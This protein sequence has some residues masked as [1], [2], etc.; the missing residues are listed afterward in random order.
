VLLAAVMLFSC[1]SRA[2]EPPIEAVMLPGDDGGAPAPGADGTTA[3]H[4]APDAVS[5]AVTSPDASGAPDAP[6]D[7]DAPEDQDV[8]GADPFAAAVAIDLHADVVFQVAERDRD[9]FRDDGQWTIDRARRGGLDAQFFPLWI[10]PRQG[11]QQAALQRAV[12]AFR[13][14]IDGSAGVLAVVRTASEIRERSRA[15]LLS[16]LLGIEGALPLG[17]DPANVD[18]LIELGLRYLGLTWNKSNAFAEAAADPRRPHG[19]TAAGRRLVARANDAGVLLDLA[20]ASAQTF[21]DTHRLSRSP[22]LVSH[23]GLR[24][25][26]DI[27][28]NIDDLQ[29]L[30]LA[31]S[32]GVLGIVWHSGFLADL[33]AGQTVAPL[34]ALL[35]AYDHARALGALPALALGSD[36]DGGIRPPQELAAI[37]LLPALPLALRDRGWSDDEIIA[38][39][40]ENFLRLLDAAASTVADTASPSPEDAPAAFA[41]DANTAAADLSPASTSPA[42][43]AAPR[44]WP[45][46]V[47]ST[48]PLSRDAARL[49]DRLLLP[50]PMVDP[51]TAIELEWSGDDAATAAVL[52]IWGQPDAPLVVFGGLSATARDRDAGT[53]A[54]LRLDHR[55]NGRL[56][57]DAAAL[58]ERR[59]TIV[60]AA[61][62]SE[63]PDD[64]SPKPVR[65]DEIAVWLR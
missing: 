15:G 50:G 14:V 31:R 56:E 34:S 33:P 27:P 7:S 52:E 39:L 48:G 37:D 45:A 41:R 26:R 54:V 60:P 2:P 64:D 47:A 61:P 24:A 65:I 32:G 5:D 18:P 9:F 20:H 46:D 44:E 62:A 55:G 49:T 17:D 63:R 57:L 21:W 23:A 58:R 22:L 36:L 43:A 29:L 8:A 1:R 42:G 25:L 30:A 10:S 13:G 38:V 51:L 12:V 16:A 59:L 53:R 6:A 19:L 35:D 4:D 11:D 28:R 3:G 40:G